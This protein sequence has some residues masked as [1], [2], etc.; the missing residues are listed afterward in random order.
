MINAPFFCVYPVYV[1]IYIYIYIHTHTHTHTHIYIYIYIYNVRRESS[2]HFRNKTKEYVNAK[3]DDI[4]TNIEIEI[5]ETCAW[6]LIAL[7]GLP[8]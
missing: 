4:K 5:S 2:R 7:K 8:A 1:Y 6:T 3:I